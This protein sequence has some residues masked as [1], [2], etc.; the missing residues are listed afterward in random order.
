MFIVNQIE[1]NNN[2]PTRFRFMNPCKKYLEKMIILSP[3]KETSGVS[4]AEG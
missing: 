2:G 3:L 1:K 4:D